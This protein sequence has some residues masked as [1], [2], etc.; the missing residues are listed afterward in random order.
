MRVGQCFSP[1]TRRR[2]P[3]VLV[4]LFT[5]LARKDNARI[6]MSSIYLIEMRINIPFLSQIEKRVLF[7][8]ALA[9]RILSDAILERK[10]IRS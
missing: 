7:L 6:C 8:D 10:L 5:T 3:V 1:G 2:D 4:V 9:S